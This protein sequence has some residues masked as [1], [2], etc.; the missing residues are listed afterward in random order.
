MESKDVRIKREEAR[1]GFS[2]K[3]RGKKNSM[4]FLQVSKSLHRKARSWKGKKNKDLPGRN[5]GGTEG[6]DVVGGGSPR[7][8]GGKSPKKGGGRHLSSILKKRLERQKKESSKRRGGLKN[9][10][11]MVASTRYPDLPAHWVDRKNNGSAR[12]KGKNA[13]QSLR[14]GRSRTSRRPREE[15]RLSALPAALQG[16]DPCSRERSSRKRKMICLFGG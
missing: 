2:Y 3:R 12:R 4:R 1:G 10:T 8:G 16:A 9:F 15:S 11:A 6:A 7:T 5:W 13:P 14:R